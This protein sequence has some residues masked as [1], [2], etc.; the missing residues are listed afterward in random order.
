M[1]GDLG[2]K[3]LD[4]SVFILIALRVYELGTDMPFPR[5]IRLDWIKGK[6]V[7]RPA[8]LSKKLCIFFP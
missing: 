4:L 8:D 1:K 7:P 5:G 2:R 6:E 3:G